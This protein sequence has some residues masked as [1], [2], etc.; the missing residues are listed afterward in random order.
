M[1]S[2]SGTS[3][4]RDAPTRPASLRLRSTW[5]E[6]IPYAA[7]ASERRH[8]WRSVVSK[9]PS[10]DASRR[11]AGTFAPHLEES[12]AP[13]SG[14]WRSGSGRCMTWAVPTQ[15]PARPQTVTPGSTR[16]PT[17]K[18]VIARREHESHPPRDR[19]EP[20]PKT[21]FPTPAPKVRMQGDQ[22][23]VSTVGSPSQNPSPRS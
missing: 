13:P 15:P 2:A 6:R 7:V 3:A 14:S 20:C 18:T 10:R 19:A 1:I 22:P 12:S 16:G 21:L 17:Q 4:E 9:G 11:Y 5:C 23:T 8:C